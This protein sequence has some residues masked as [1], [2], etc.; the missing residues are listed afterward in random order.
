MSDLVFEVTQEEDGGFFAECLTENIR[1]LTGPT[2][3]PP[4]S[5]TYS[6]MW[7]YGEAPGRL[8]RGPQ[9]GW[10]QGW[11]RRGPAGSAV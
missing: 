9:D 3:E 11:R 4:R 7:Y 5:T 10:V 8:W 2:P 1:I 6:N